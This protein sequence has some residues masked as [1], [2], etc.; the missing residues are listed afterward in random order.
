MHFIFD[1]MTATIVGG[2]VL[3]MLFM[4]QTRIQSNTIEST[5]M[6][7]AKKQ[8]L[9]FAETLERDFANAGYLSVPG[10]EAI[11]AHSN[12]NDGTT[13][14]TDTLEFWGAD[15]AGL[16]TRV[17]YTLVP[18]DTVSIQGV[19]EQ[20][21]RVERFEHDGFGWTSTGASMPSI[22]EFRVDLL[23]SANNGVV[24]RRD[25]RKLRVRFENAVVGQRMQGDDRLTPIYLRKLR[26]GIT[27]SPRGLSMQTFQ[28]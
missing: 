28:G 1:K 7:A 9:S 20:L 15:A 23:D 25:A 6:Y 26:W 21:Y 18:V 22:T 13:S 27:L 11:L 19:K 3:M 2:I 16:R 24:D 5:I 17:R 8:T 12:K 10:D 14:L 4:L